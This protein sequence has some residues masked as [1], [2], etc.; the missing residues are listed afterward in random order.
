MSRVPN[1][2]I[3]DTSRDRLQ[4]LA[5]EY[6]YLGYSIKLSHGKLTVFAVPRKKKKDD[7]KRGPESADKSGNRVG[8]DSARSKR[9][10]RVDA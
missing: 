5:D 6:I 4:R 2:H 3:H 10:R 7:K 1:L 8:K 9:P